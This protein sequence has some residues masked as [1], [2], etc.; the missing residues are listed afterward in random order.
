MNTSGIS[1]FGAAGQ[2][3]TDGVVAGD[4]GE[5]PFNLVQVDSAS[6]VPQSGG[7]TNIPVRI[8]TAGYSAAPDGYEAPTQMFVNT[9]VGELSGQVGLVTS[10]TADKGSIDAISTVAAHASRIP[11]KYVTAKDYVGYINPDN[12]PTQGIRRDQYLAEPKYVL[13]TKQEYS[14]ATAQVS[15][16]FLATGGRDATVG[17]FVNAIKKGNKVVILDNRQ[18]KADVWNPSKLRP[19]NASAYLVAKLAGEDLPELPGNGFTSEFRSQYAT[20]IASLVKVVTINSS[21]DVATAAHEAAIF[22]NS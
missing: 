18:I 17:D 3:P 6:Q 13:P 1:G 5:N 2:V 9:L 19:D 22:L 12:F 15:N 4:G 8:A 10:P 7:W 20:Q 11:V 14:I 16:A 21:A